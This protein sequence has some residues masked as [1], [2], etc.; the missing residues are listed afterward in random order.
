M[1]PLAARFFLLLTMLPACYGA[2]VQGVV[3][4]HETGLP[5]A[6]AYVR[7]IPV[8]GTAAKPV[9]MFAAERGTFAVL[10]VTPGWYILRTEKKMF[11]AAEAGQA[12]A[13]RPGHPFLIEKDDQSFFLEM[14]M[15]RLGA[16]SGQVVDEN[17]VGLPE[18]PVVLYTAKRP[19]HQVANSKTDDRG[20]FRVW[21]LSPGQY[22]ARSAEGLLEDKTSLLPTYHRYGTNPSEALPVQ[23]RLGQT[24]M[25]L[26]IQPVKGR[27]FSIRGTATGQSIQSVTLITELDRRLLSAPNFTAEHVPPGRVDILIEG[28]GVGGKCAGLARLNVDRDFIGVTIP[29]QPIFRNT[30][31]FSAPSSLGSRLRPNHIWYRRVDL[32]GISPEKQIGS[33]P[34]LPGSYQFQLRPPSD[35]IWM[36]GLSDGQREHE[37]AEGWFSGEVGNYS[38]L[39]IDV[40]GA[41]PSLTGAVVLDKIPAIGAPVYIGEYDPSGNTR[42]QLWQLRS[43]TTGHYR[44]GGLHPGTYRVLSSFDFDT[45]DRY[46]MGKAPLI[47]L[48]EGDKA[49][50]DLTVEP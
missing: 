14:R 26:R 10:N 44:L 11:A 16:V 27:L 42:L 25:D 29:C 3:L 39:R 50:Q 4:E 19:Y 20:N 5:L 17:G 28:S 1:L 35:D 2:V 32:D 6:R 22:L 9:E 24:E 41:A 38:S 18:W 15:T 12:R 47:T 49:V 33:E 37:M 43:D 30:V 13:G 46:A 21:E 31:S 8:E 34:M 36:T 48:K 40:K 23:V 45:E 7:L